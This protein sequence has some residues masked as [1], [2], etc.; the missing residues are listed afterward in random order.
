MPLTLPCTHQYLFLKQLAFFWGQSVS[1]G[2][3]G[4]D[5]DFVMKSLHELDVQGLQTEEQ[6]YVR[7]LNVENLS[8]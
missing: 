6:K 7:M 2:N 5:V 1:F 4:N 3:E 8:P